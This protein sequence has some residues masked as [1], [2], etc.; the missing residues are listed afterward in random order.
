MRKVTNV[1]QDSKG[2]FTLHTL[3]DSRYILDTDA[4]TLSRHHD[5]THDWSQDLKRQVTY[6]IVHIRECAVG[7]AADLVISDP[8][9]SA[10]GTVSEWN[11]SSVVKILA[12][13]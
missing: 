5:D 11:S 9:S 8:R 6:G 7:A 10:P 12:H 2:I 1:S 3:N 4:M 13:Q